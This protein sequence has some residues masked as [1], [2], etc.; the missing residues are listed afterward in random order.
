MAQVE[1]LYPEDFPPLLQHIP[2]PPSHLFLRGCL[3]PKGTKYLTVVGSRR[4]SQ[5]GKDACEHLISGLADYPIAIVSGLAI[6]LDTVAHR[7]A[8]R[9]GLRTIALP[10]SG[11]NDNVLYPHSNRPLAKEILAAGGALMSEFDPGQRTMIHFFPQRNRIMAGMSDA[12]LIVEAGVQSG[13]LIT[14][15]LASDYGRDLLIV[16]HQIFSEGG[17]GGHIFMRLGAAPVRSASDILETLGIVEEKSI[18]TLHLTKEEEAVLAL[19]DEPQ[20]RDEII[21]ALGMPTAEVTVL[22]AQM[23]LRGLVGESLGQVRKLL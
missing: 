11:I 3:P 7:A 17:T 4:M 14:A 19:L 15:R 12:V 2:D 9:H 1:K 5:Y 23:E 6:G 20:P 8:L 16:P 10:G 22:L 13:T 21:R 18:E